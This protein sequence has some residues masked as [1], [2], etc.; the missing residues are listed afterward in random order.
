MDAENG[1]IPAVNVEVRRG[2]IHLLHLSVGS[3]FPGSRTQVPVREPKFFGF[4][5]LLLRV[6]DA[7]VSNETLK[8]LVVVTGQ[9]VHTVTAKAR[10]HCTHTFAVNVRF[11]GNIVD[12]AEVV[13]HA[14]TRVVARNGLKP[15]HA[16]ARKSA[17]VRRNNDVVVGSHNLEVPAVAPELAHGRLRATLAEEQGRILFI[18]VE[19]WRIYHP[20]KHFFVVYRIDPSFFH[21]AKGQ[22][23]VEVLVFERQLFRRFVFTF[24]RKSIHLIG[25]THAVL[26]HKERSTIGCQSEQRI[27]SHLISQSLVLTF[28][29]RGVHLSFA[30][31]HTGKVQVLAV[32][33]P[34]KF[35][36]ATFKLFSNI[37]FFAGFEVEHT[38]ARTVAFVAVAFHAAPCHVASVGRELRV[39][40]V[41]HVAVSCRFVHRLMLQRTV[42]L[43]FGS[44]VIG[45]FAKVLGRSG[46]HFVKEDVAV[47]TDSI[48][49]A[50][51]FAAGISN[52][53]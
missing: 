32:R 7:V 44:H 13:L 4:D 35:V 50:H 51:L 24:Y 49:L 43:N 45:R 2:G 1:R 34:A 19:M 9:P 41:T 6:V 33:C 52:A 38:K 26:L 37:R 21:L 23:V 5:I 47:R 31:P 16:K 28:Q 17:A 42:S 12:G 3:L 36:D 46:A 27:I 39:L 10:T 20:A 40:V 11:F 14:K 18:R 53:F 29:V 15:F 30:V 22:F 48:A 8:A 25:L